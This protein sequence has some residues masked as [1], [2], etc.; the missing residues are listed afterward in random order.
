MAQNY[1]T[2]NVTHKISVNPNQKNFFQCRLEDW[3]IRLGVWIALLHNRRRSYGVGKATENC[4]FLGQN[5][6]MNIS[7][8]SSHSVTGEVGGRTAGLKTLS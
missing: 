4:W 6:G 5:L 1:F 3:L 8:A 7:N 2:Y